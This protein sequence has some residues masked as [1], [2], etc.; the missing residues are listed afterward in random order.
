MAISDGKQRIMPTPEDLLPGRGKQLVVPESVL[1]VNP[2]N[3]DLK[4]EVD[5]KYQYSMNNEESG[6]TGWISSGPF[7]GFWIIFPS[8]EFRSGGPTKQNLTLHTG[9][10]CLAMFHGM[11]YIGDEMVAQF[12]A[13]EAWT[14]VLGPIFVY[15]NST[16]TISN[17]HNL[18]IDAKR[19]RL[20]EEAAW[21]YDFVSSPHYITA[22]GRGSASG[23]LLVQDNSLIPANCAHVGLSMASTAGGWQTESKSYQF[24]AKTDSNGNFSI[25]NVIP[26]VYRLHGWVPGFIGDY[27]GK[28]V[29]D[30]TSGSDIQ[31]G[32]LV[33]IPP[34]D[35]PT[36]WEIG[37]PDRTASGYYVP[38][39][40]PKYAN[41]VFL[42]SQDKFRQYGL[43]DRYTDENPESEQT[44]T[45]GISD[46]RKDWF[47]AH[48]NRFELFP[49]PPFS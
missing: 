20:I 41:R 21:P 6:V 46:P 22:S 8:H 44:F 33:Y 30:I 9:P 19:Q 36:V 16:P 31:L 2:I 32:D 17:A 37:F 25:S 40:N 47:F 42:N 28:G 49:F 11:D 29:V 14:K 3:P 23:K 7:I 27:L 10:A 13:G 38:E 45:V 4:G 43:W 35:G 12:E 34:R 15:L 18:W 26:G 24:W 5:D 1:L 48:V 39:V